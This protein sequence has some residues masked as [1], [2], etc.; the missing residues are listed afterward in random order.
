MNRESAPERVGN[1]FDVAP[2][3]RHDGVVATHGTFSDGDIDDVGETAPGDQRADLSSL[4]FQH[5]LHLAA[6]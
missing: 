5:V 1:L 6:L 2:V 3:G 4:D